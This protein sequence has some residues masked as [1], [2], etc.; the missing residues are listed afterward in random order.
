MLSDLR[1]G[2]WN[3]PQDAAKSIEIDLV[4]LDEPNRRIRFG[5]CKRA[6]DAH[7][8]TALKKFEQHIEGFLQ[9]RQHRELQNWQHEKALLPLNS[10]KSSGRLCPDRGIS[11]RICTI[12]A[13]WF[14][15]ACEG[16]LGDHRQPACQQFRFAVRV[17]GRRLDHF[18]ELALA[19]SWTF[20]PG[21]FASLPEFLLMGRR[22]GGQIKAPVALLDHLRLDDQPPVVREQF[23]FAPPEIVEH[24][25]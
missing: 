21:F 17:N 6:A 20:A 13:S 12:T 2:Y 15:T 14:E 5:S 4:A 19:G 3:R 1:L 18:L 16:F 10:A 8:R 23:Q 24:V 25:V 7:D 9:T 11:A 22:G